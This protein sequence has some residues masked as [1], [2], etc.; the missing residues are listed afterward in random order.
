MP[1]LNHTGYEHFVMI[2]DVFRKHS[3]EIKCYICPITSKEGNEKYKHLDKRILIKGASAR[4]NLSLEQVYLREGYMGKTSYI[5]VSHVFEI[6]FSLL[7]PMRKRNQDQVYY[8]RLLKQS[9]YRLM[10]EFDL[11][12]GVYGNTWFVIQFG[13][14]IRS[15]DATPSLNGSSSGEMETRLLDRESSEFASSNAPSQALITLSPSTSQPIFNFPDRQ[16]G[17]ILSALNTPSTHASISTLPVRGSII[18]QNNDGNE[19]STSTCQ[20]EASEM[21]LLDSQP[22]PNNSSNPTN[23]T[24]E[25]PHT[26]S[27]L[28]QLHQLRHPPPLDLKK[29]LALLSTPLSRFPH[30]L[31]KA[32]FFIGTQ[33]WGKLC[34]YSLV[35]LACYYTG[36]LK[37]G[38]LAIKG[39]DGWLETLGNWS[40]RGNFNIARVLG[41][42]MKVWGGLA[43]P[44]LLR[45]VK[46]V[47]GL[48]KDVGLW[49]VRKIVRRG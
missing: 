8:R 18:E 11:K 46:V 31:L 44:V 33:P 9:Y 37:F 7:K 29:A 21:A 2:L 17:T 15:K 22:V 4:P 42:L 45:V 24:T 10:R 39:L 48:L 35:L 28:H 19:N 41:G 27:K 25:A 13:A 34:L 5:R 49:A 3:G 1:E 47:G 23:I 16:Y 26:P 30:Y 12:P 6:S 43:S 40:V 32:I 38:F 14:T 36:T 20:L